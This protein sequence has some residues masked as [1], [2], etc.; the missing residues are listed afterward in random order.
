MNQDLQDIQTAQEF[1]Q[2]VNQS[3]MP[4]VVE[5]WAPWCGPCKAFG[6]ILE[7]AASR[8]GGEAIVAKVNID[9]LQDVALEQ[10]VSSIPT[11]F[12]YAGGQLQRAEGGIVSADAIVA[13]VNELSATA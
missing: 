3:E 8:L 4:L 6:P 12:Y 13:K 2:L 5:F 1:K 10:G 11:L 7:Q 9:D